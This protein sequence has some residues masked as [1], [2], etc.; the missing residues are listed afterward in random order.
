VVHRA[1]PEDLGLHISR[2]SWDYTS[3]GTA[4]SNTPHSHGPAA[5]PHRSVRRE[6]FIGTPGVCVGEQFI[7]NQQVT[8][9]R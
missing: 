2:H 1:R 4:L 3:V 5:A 9:G 7:D 8:E 6:E